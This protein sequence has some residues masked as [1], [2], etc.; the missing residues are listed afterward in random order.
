[1][2]THVMLNKNLMTNDMKYRGV[3]DVTHEEWENQWKPEIDD[4][5]EVIHYDGR[6]TTNRVTYVHTNGCAYISGDQDVHLW[7]NMRLKERKA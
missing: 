4:V 3:R 6:V 5:V 7:L 1:M 2:V